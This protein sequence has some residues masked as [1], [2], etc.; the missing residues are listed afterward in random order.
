MGLL[1]TPDN[2]PLSFHRKE[3]EIVAA[4]SNQPDAV[5]STLRAKK[6]RPPS[7]PLGPNSPL[8]TGGPTTA[9]R[10]QP[11][12]RTQPSASPEC[13]HSGYK[14][15]LLSSADM[16]LENAL[17]NIT[18]K[19][20]SIRCGTSSCTS[21]A[22]CPYNQ[23]TAQQSYGVRMRFFCRCCRYEIFANIVGVSRSR[24]T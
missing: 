3:R 13:P 22:F 11:I 7:E 5:L 17:I 8:G 4:L 10:A 1:S 14:L 18:R 9:Q 19:H 24:M 15:S 2:G 23:E 16:P 6:P 20:V 12:D 21:L